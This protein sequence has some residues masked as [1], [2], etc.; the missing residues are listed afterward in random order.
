LQ[1]SGFSYYDGTACHLDLSQWATDPTWNRLTD[2][3]RARLVASDAPF[4]DDQLR[5]EGIAWLLLNGAGVTRAFSSTYGAHLEDVSCISDRRVRTKIA[6]GIY[7]KVN[8]IAWSTNLQSS[9]GVTRR[10]R[11]LLAAEVARLMA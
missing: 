2:V 8:V 1:C 6:C 4:L 9:F 5:D 7:S 11:G 3:A 10:L